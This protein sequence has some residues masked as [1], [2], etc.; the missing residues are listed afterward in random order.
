MNFRRAT[1]N[2]PMRDESFIDLFRRYPPLLMLCIATAIIMLGQGLTTPVLPLY[3]KSFSASAA[4][5]GLTIS[6]FGL[7]RMILNIPVGLASDR[8][9]RRFVLIGGPL[10]VFVSSILSGLAGSLGELLVW[11]FAAGA[12]SAMY[13]TGATVYL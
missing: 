3:A 1:R 9:G 4:S 6:A 12:G 10:I 2:L 11:R 8:L 7:A 13:L 5:V